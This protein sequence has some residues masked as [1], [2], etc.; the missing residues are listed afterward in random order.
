MANRR[1][2]NLKK[3]ARKCR[4][5]RA[6]TPK[7]KNLNLCDWS[8]FVTNTNE[9]QIASEM[10]RSVYRIRWSIELIFKNW[11]SILKIHKSNV[12]KNENRLKVELYG[13][14]IFA[15][16]T[17]KV[18][19]SIAPFLW[20]KKNKELSMWCVTDFLLRRTDSMLHAIRIS[21]KDFVRLIN[22]FTPKIIQTCVKHY[23]PSR[24]TTLQMIDEFIGDNKPMK[25]VI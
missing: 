20:F 18:Y 12:I 4:G 6:Y 2:A 13:K 21:T 10:I 3:N 17:H 9:K 11:K 1:R 25:V 14:L 8:I 5:K 7:K 22:S 23:Q 16:L 15:V 24:K 19:Q